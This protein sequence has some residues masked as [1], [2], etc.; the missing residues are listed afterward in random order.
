MEF[1]EDVARLDPDA[2]RR[3]PG[4]DEEPYSPLVKH[5]RSVVVRI[6]LDGTW[7]VLS[8][9]IVE[10][11]GY[12]PDIE[13]P[14]GLRDAVHP[15]DIATAADALRAVRA[16][17]LPAARTDIRVLSAD[18]RWRDMDT[19]FYDM[20]D[21]SGV[22]AVIA[23]A[24]DVT[25]QRAA[26]RRSRVEGKRLRALVRQLDAAVLVEDE[27]GRTV[28]ANDTFAR[29]F[30]RTSAGA[31]EDIERSEVLGAVASRCRE[32]A[33]VRAQLDDVATLRKMFLGYGLELV[34]GRSLSLDFVPI[35][36]GDTDLGA[37]WSSGTSP[38]SP[39]PSTSS[40][41]ATGC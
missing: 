15:D 16:R 29:V 26:E 12:S 5:A 41:S 1:V 8:D 19:V 36:D 30:G 9:A 34:N 3:E 14:S 2:I 4:L 38:R 10:A 31:W 6:G 28:M 33:T 22:H 11:L 18:G 24:L 20:T 7:S 13:L 39:R 35:R 37:L 17:E 40:A 27:N 25:D 32:R 23:Y 21:V